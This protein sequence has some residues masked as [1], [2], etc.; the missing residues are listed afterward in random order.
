MD[1]WR[2]NGGRFET[3]LGAQTSLVLTLFID[4]KGRAS[5]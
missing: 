1:L 2:E 5:Q 3:Y 4:S